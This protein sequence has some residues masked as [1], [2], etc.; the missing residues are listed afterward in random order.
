DQIRF[1]GLPAVVQIK[2]GFALW[3][4]SIVVANCATHRYSAPLRLVPRDAADELPSLDT[5]TL[6]RASCSTGRPVRV[7]VRSQA[8]PFVVIVRGVAKGV[9]VLTDAK[10]ML[11]HA[12]GRGQSRTSF[13]VCRV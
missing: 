11:R 4:D 7:P 5:V 9:I 6:I 1:A 8:H 13:G 3:D 12:P 10:V 2:E